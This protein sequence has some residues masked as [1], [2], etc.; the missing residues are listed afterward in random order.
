MVSSRTSTFSSVVGSDVGTDDV[1]HW[2]SLL[3]TFIVDS[4]SA[5]GHP[6]FY[7]LMTNKNGACAYSVGCHPYIIALYFLSAS[8][9]GSGRTLQMDQDRLCLIGQ[10]GLHF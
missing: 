5:L 9:S 8:L 2:Q 3:A 6:Y 1:S 4:V 10:S 7:L